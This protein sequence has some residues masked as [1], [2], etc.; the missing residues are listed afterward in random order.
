[1]DF[2]DLARRRASVRGYR[3]DPVEDPLVEQVLEA[4]RA[5]P[6][7]TNRQ[8]W[9]VVLVTSEARRQALF[10]AYPRDWFLQAP[11]MLAV[12]T[13]P[14]AAWNRPD[15]KNYAD[16]DGAIAMD[17][18]TLCAA[19]LGL[20]TCWIGAF[21]AEKVRAA[22]GLPEGI[23]PLAL[24]PLGWPAD[25]GRPKRRKPLGDLLHRERW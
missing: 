5:A 25:A 23:E 22:L 8:P 3:P 1:M 15:G 4:G 9:H 2:L 16:V 11:V 19:S 12:C 24:T 21:D 17:H 14:G 10:E 18:M 20:G 7:A 6:S 13:E